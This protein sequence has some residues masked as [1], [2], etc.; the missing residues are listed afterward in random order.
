MSASRAASPLIWRWWRV[1]AAVAGA[2]IIGFG[3]LPVAAATGP[4]VAGSSGFD[5]SYPNCSSPLPNGDSFAIVGVT[6]GRPFS[7]YSC[8]GDLWNA[9][10]TAIA[11]K[12]GATESLY[13]NTGYSGAY[14]KDISSSCSTAEE[15]SF[16]GPTGLSRHLQ[17]QAEQA[18]EI[19]CS[20]VD[21]AIAAFK[22]AGVG[23]APTM[24]FADIETGNSW[25]NNV[26]LNQYAIDGISWGM[27]NLRSDTNQLTVGYTGIYSSAKMWTT[28]TGSSVRSFSPTTPVEANWVT[29]G[30]CPGTLSSPSTS[31]S[32]FDSGGTNNTPTWLAQGAAIE[33]VDTDTVC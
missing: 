17:K 19:G 20:E 28:I 3:V 16:T 8:F 27:V 6:G 10:K 18:W 25:S 1:R 23:P 29:Q 2:A 13:F 26:T 30:T 5:V 12:S 22:A 7:T 9:A 11:E 14:G 24:L 15:S 31:P 33:G 32:A 4:F 21:Y